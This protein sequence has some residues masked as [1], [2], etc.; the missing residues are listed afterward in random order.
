MAVFHY[1]AQTADGNVVEGQ[2]DN[3][4]RQEALRQLADRGLRPLNLRAGAET[5]ASKQPAAGGSSFDGL[6]RGSRVSHKALGN[7]TRQLSSLLSAG[8][9]LSRALH[10]LSRQGSSPA[11][12][13][14]WRSI[15]DLVV[16]GNSLA[17]AMSQHGDIFPRVYVAMVRA[18]E[19]GGFLELV[20]AQI[21]EFQTR[22]RELRAKV[23]SALVY[24]CVLLALTVAVMIFLMTFFIPRFQGIFE[25]FGAALPWL[26]QA[27]IASS[28][29]VTRYGLFVAAALAIGAYALRQYFLSEAGR[30]Q[31][32]QTVLKIPVAGPL[33]ARLAMARFCRMLGTLA[34]A[35]VPLINSLRVSRESLGN[36]VLL[37]ALSASIERVQKG[38]PLAAS[39]GDCP[40]LF[41]AEAVEMIAV[42]EE[43]GRLDK[44]LVRI[45]EVTEKELEG[46]IRTAVALIEPLMLFVMAAFIGTIF[47]GMVIPI[48][49]IQEYIK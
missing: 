46:Q 6:A 30:R 16:D 22:E 42:A 9:S 1:K 5:A 18:G 48:F 45:A 23:T 32:H 17:N 25:G 2:I 20:L 27:I 10:L 19:T 41:P 28:H 13:A 44:E 33:A 26:T 31:W 36:Q 43:S 29:A 4:S 34:A 12:S 8:V 15:H 35:G 11:V 40:K 3:N 47:V 14:R 38:D 39:L 49:T 7:F 21:A 37:D 24:P